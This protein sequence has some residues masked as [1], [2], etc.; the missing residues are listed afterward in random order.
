L[1]R[2]RS[3]RRQFVVVPLFE[4]WSFR[5][6][7]RHGREAGGPAMKKKVVADFIAVVVPAHG[8]Y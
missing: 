8:G 2:E 5:E 1:K 4:R 6:D 7:K 3:S